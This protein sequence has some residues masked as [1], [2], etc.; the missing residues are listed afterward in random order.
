MPTI[1]LTIDATQAARIQAALAATDYPAT[2]AGYKQFLVDHTIN[3]VQEF[4]RAQAQKTA[5]ATIVPPAEL[6]VT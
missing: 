4:E 6:Q 5:L 3:L 2:L 1:S